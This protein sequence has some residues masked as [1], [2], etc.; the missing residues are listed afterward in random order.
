MKIQFIMIDRVFIKYKFT[1]KSKSMENEFLFG[2]SGGMKKPKG[3]PKTTWQ[4]KVMKKLEEMG[5]SWAK[6]RLK[7]GIEFRCGV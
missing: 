1:K 4:R 3:S 2:L 5:V 6:H 7:H